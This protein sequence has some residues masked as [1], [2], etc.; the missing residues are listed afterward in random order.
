MTSVSAVVRA[1]DVV[2]VG[3]FM[4][5]ADVDLGAVV[6]ARVRDDVSVDI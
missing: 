1:G 6:G 3:A 4:A 5:F 2:A